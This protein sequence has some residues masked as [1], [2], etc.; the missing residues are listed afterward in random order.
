ME[1]RVKAICC[2]IDGTLVRDDKSLSE[3][4]IKW[5]QKAYQA[6]VHFTLVSGRPVTGVRP[7]Y[8][9]M[10]IDGPVSCF[11][12]GTMV[13]EDGNIIDD[14]RMNF[15]T[16]ST[17]LD[18][19]DRNMD[20]DMIIFDGMKW[21]L[22]RRACYCYPNKRKIYNCDCNTG[23][24][25]DLIREFDTNKVIY[26]SPSQEKLAAIVSDIKAHMD[27]SRLTLYRSGDFLE[28]MTSGYDKG[29]AI[30]A[31]ARH[32]G[33]ENDEIMALGDDF[34]DTPMLKKAGFSVA[35]ENAVED[36]KNASRYITASNNEDGVAKAI[37][38]L[39]FNEDVP[40]LRRNF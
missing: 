5:I 35:V 6:G 34:N 26:L 14:H 8:E 9:R 1:K 18:V 15:K 19:R 38:A 11:N 37:R 32:Y 21:Y 28:V 12:G 13:D 29:S 4:N 36:A 40:E 24:F 17:L 27:T 31:L 3:E 25:R 33:I 23:K 10:G 7:F 2:D 30:D 39:V 20:V 16:A 22:E